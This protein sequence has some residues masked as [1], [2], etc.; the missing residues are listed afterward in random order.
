[1]AEAINLRVVPALFD[2]DGRMAFEEWLSGRHPEMKVSRWRGSGI[3]I[4]GHGYA[5]SAEPGDTIYSTPRFVTVL[6]PRVEGDT[7]T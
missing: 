2:I 7:K 6:P 1:M 4:E 3:Y 5:V